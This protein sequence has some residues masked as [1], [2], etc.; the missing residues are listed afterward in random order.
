MMSPLY[1]QFVRLVLAYRWQRGWHYWYRGRRRAA[2]GQWRRLPQSLGLSSGE[3]YFQLSQEL[4]QTV[5]RGAAAI[6]LQWSQQRGWGSP[7][8]P[9]HSLTHS[10]ATTNAQASSLAVEAALQQACEQEPQNAPNWIKLGKLYEANQQTELAIESYLQAI[11]FSGP[12][13]LD[14]GWWQLY[15]LWLPRPLVPA[16]IERYRALAGEYPKHPGPLT[17][18]GRLLSRV[19]KPQAAI[20]AYREASRRGTLRHCGG[21]LP[22]GWDDHSPSPPQFIIIGAAKCGTSSLYT[23]LARHPNVIPSI[24]KEIDFF[25]KPKNFGYGLPW[26]LAHFPWL[27]EEAPRITG[28]ASPSYFHHPEVPQR[29]ATALPNVKLIALLR[30]PV[31]RLI[32]HYEHWVRQGYETRSLEEV[33]ATEL[34]HWQGVSPEAIEATQAHLK[35]SNRLNHNY[36]YQGLYAH[37]IQHW[38]RH[39]PPDQLLVL[40]LEEMADAPQKVLRQTCQF[41]DLPDFSLERYPQINSGQY[42]PQSDR[43]RHRQALADAFAPHAQPL[44]DLLQRPLP[45]NSPAP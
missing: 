8:D 45:W 39:F 18:L 3:V 21:Q 42:N 12:S 4:Q 11:K 22:P 24:V 31:D 37:H 38:L 5:G 16:M 27:G 1:P 25:S 32:S 33:T 23:Y 30:D 2:I 10:S 15:Y 7:Q 19:K 34:Y 14:F 43:D 17:N 44:E 35:E 40:T 26:Y 20:A 29:I 6:C 41:L 36:F 9:S 28:E 13:E